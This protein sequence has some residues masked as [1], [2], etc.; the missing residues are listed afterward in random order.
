V[1]YIPSLIEFS[2]LLC[3]TY[4]PCFT[5][6]DLSSDNRCLQ[7]QVV[8]GRA[9]IHASFGLILELIQKILK[10]NQTLDF[11]MGLLNG[12][13]KKIKLFIVMIILL[14]DTC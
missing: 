10:R 7:S 6:E 11:Y 2:Q 4:L 3:R 13:N 14:S 12:F 8:I 9:M 5:G 1:V